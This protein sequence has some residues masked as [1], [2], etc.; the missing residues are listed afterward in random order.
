MSHF[1]LIKLKFYFESINKVNPARKFPPKKIR[2]LKN[3][4]KKLS[5]L[6]YFRCFFCEKVHGENSLKKSLTPSRFYSSS[7]GDALD[8]PEN[9]VTLGLME[10]AMV[11]CRGEATVGKPSVPYQLIFTPNPAN[12]WSPDSKEDLRV[13]LHR[14][15]PGTL[16]YNVSARRIPNGPVDHLGELITRSGFVASQYGDEMLFFQHARKRW[17]PWTGGAYSERNATARLLKK[18]RNLI[19][20]SFPPPDRNVLYFSIISCTLLYQ[21]QIFR[22]SFRFDEIRLY[23]WTGHMTHNSVWFCA[24]RRTCG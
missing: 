20:E 6:E 9:E 16:L 12:A 14:I 21:V 1:T 13:H 17:Q 24:H 11:N 15:P 4:P 23:F 8:K 10:Q 19:G 5:T 2:N 22:G 7:K 18:L 3:S